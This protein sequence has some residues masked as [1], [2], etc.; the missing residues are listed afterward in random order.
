MNNKQKSLFVY[1]FGKGKFERLCAFALKNFTLV[2]IT[3]AI[4]MAGVMTLL[5]IGFNASRDAM[6]DNYSSDMRSEEHTSELQSH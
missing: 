1:F 5:P 3:L 4:G 6:G 2:E